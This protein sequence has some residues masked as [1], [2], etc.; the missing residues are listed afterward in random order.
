MRKFSEVLTEAQICE[1]V[2]AD[3]FLEWFVVAEKFSPKM[4]HTVFVREALV[5]FV[6]TVKS[7]EPIYNPEYQSAKDALGVFED[8]WRAVYD[9][10]TP[11]HDNW[12]YYDHPVF[13]NMGH[14]MTSY[15]N[16]QSVKK[17]DAALKQHKHKADTDHDG[18]PYR[19]IFD[20]LTEIMTAYRAFV[21]AWKALKPR[22][23]SGRRP[24]EV[25]KDE[26]GN[27]IGKLGSH[28]AIAAVTTA[29]KNQFGP[30]LD[31]F[32]KRRVAYHASIFKQLSD[33]VHGKTEI[34][35]S[36]IPPEWGMHWQDGFDSKAD[37]R[38]TGAPH[39]NQL[40]FYV[41]IKA[42]DHHAM[43]QKKGKEDRDGVEQSFMHKN[44][45]KLSN[46]VEIKGIHVDITPI[47]HAFI[48]AGSIEGSLHFKFPDGSGFDVKN[49]VIINSRQDSRFYQY[50][51][52]FH[53]VVLADGTKM[54]MPSEQKMF[55]EFK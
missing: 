14:D 6:A 25:E 41:Q 10:P 38:R 45:K 46:I 47:G 3:K 12:F 28:E 50:P 53:N 55:E 54:K 19:H 34:S 26:R 51:T 13:K 11:G 21:E 52:T 48:D 27:F 33:L 35:R 29:L 17:I 30:L 20:D 23:V 18:A 31:E 1:S 15:L 44:I 5:K 8:A 37:Y 4:R 24:K 9:R 43:A 32:E 16:A 39:F 2:D 42:R 7:D 49:K 36:D 22:V 40:L